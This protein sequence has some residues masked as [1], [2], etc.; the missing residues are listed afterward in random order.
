MFF[1]P[2]T[3]AAVLLA[4]VTVVAQEPGSIPSWPPPKFVCGT[5]S[6]DKATKQSI[7]RTLQKVK[8]DEVTKGSDSFFSNNNDPYNRSYHVKT[9]FHII[10]LN[11]QEKKYFEEVNVIQQNL[12]ALNRVYNKIGIY[13]VFA[14]SIAI[15][16]PK[17]AKGG[18]EEEMKRGLPKGHRYS[19][20]NIYLLSSVREH[21]PHLQKPG[22][23]KLGYALHPVP[24]PDAYLMLMDGVTINAHEAVSDSNPFNKEKQRIIPIIIHEVGHWLGLQH[25]FEAGCNGVGDGIDDTPAQSNATFGCPPQRSS[26]KEG[27]LIGPEYNY[28]DY[29]GK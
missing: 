29:A 12:D 22:F 8:E 13:F 27:E 1:L 23:E 7:E 18:Y 16:N 20:L 15:V 9:Y 14:C 28:M 6:L 4:S 11:G 26:C 17:W 5:K 19:H 25:T 10:A 24:N 3:L 21:E 2:T